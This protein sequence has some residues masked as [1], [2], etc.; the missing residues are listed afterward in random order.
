MSLSGG[1]AKNIE[2]FKASDP[3]LSTNKLGFSP[4]NFDFDIFSK[5]IFTSSGEYLPESKSA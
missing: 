1:F 2:T 3:Y 5:V 4:L